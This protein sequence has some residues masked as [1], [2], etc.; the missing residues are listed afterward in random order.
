MEN[1]DAECWFLVKENNFIGLHKRGKFRGKVTS[2]EK[3]TK[4]DYVKVVAE[5]ELI[6][7]CLSKFSVDK[8]DFTKLFVKS[9]D[10]REKFVTKWRGLSPGETGVIAAAVRKENEI[11][12]SDAKEHGQIADVMPSMSGEATLSKAISKKRK[13]ESQQELSGENI[14]VDVEI[15]S[16][17]GFHMISV[18]HLKQPNWQHLLREPKRFHVEDLKKEFLLNPCNY[19]TLMVVNIP[20]V[21]KD[22]F[23]V[24]E[25]NNYE[26]ETIGGNH[27]RVALQ[28]LLTDCQ[29]SEDKKKFFGKKLVSVY[30]DLSN[31]EAR[32]IGNDHNSVHKFVMGMTFISR[33]IS[34]RT[35]LFSKIDSSE[36]EAFMN[37]EPPKDKGILQ[38]WRNGLKLST[39]TKGKLHD[40]FRVELNLAQSSKRLWAALM[41]FVE[42]W[43]LSEIKGQKKKARKTKELGI[44]FFKKLLF[45]SEDEQVTFL[46]RMC[47]GEISYQ[48]VEEACSKPKTECVIDEPI[49][50]DLQ[51]ESIEHA[52]DEREDNNLQE[53]IKELHRKNCEMKEKFDKQ[54][55][56]LIKENNNMSTEI[57][58]LKQQLRNSQAVDERE[59]NNLQEEIK[60][61]HRRNC[62]MKTKFDK[63]LEVLIKENNNMATEIEDLKEQLRNSQVNS[64]GK[65]KKME[66]LSHENE[67]LKTY[68]SKE[69]I[70]KKL[71]PGPLE[72]LEVEIKYKFGLTGKNVS[73]KM[74]V[75]I[76]VAKK[77]YK[78]GEPWLGEIIKVNERSVLLQWLTGSY[79]AKWAPDQLYQPETI[80]KDKIICWCVWDTDF[81]MPSELR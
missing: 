45:V 32:R 76:K 69:K 25:I 63:Q 75:G 35:A 56:V 52:V 37:K 34:F 55:E 26:L 20:D 33:V 41:H 80:K 67:K 7:C 18:S 72:E 13:F 10:S 5:G 24:A 12:Q 39:G 11:V 27:T 66:K 44:R 14:D 42:K 9:C 38:K 70:M 4:R 2:I 49:N 73:L 8:N 65:R 58:D 51:I 16:A 77:D 21:T 62:E 54:L 3:S 17:A 74:I 23:S 57:E 68:K 19:F 60:E 43:E 30:G 59:D 50:P 81:A 48:D 31:D 64:T 71:T 61:L 15:Q 1:H 78:A 79:E 29:V 28:E 53:E 6:L 36:P 40:R 47:E 46:R 22:I